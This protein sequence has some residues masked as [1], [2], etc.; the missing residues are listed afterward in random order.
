MRAIVCSQ[1]GSPQDLRL[2]ELPDPVPGPG[3]VLVSVAAVGLGFVD[4]LHVAGRY[5]LKWPLPFTPGSEL[6]G[7][8]AGIGSDMRGLSIGQRV[9]GFCERG[10]LA[11]QVVLAASVCIAVP[12]RLD[13]V[14]AASFPTSYATALFGLRECG[15]LQANETV[16]VLGAAGGVSMAAIDVAKAMGA[17]VIAAA[18]SQAKR[19]L[20]LARG[21]DEAI[22]YTQADWRNDLKQRD[23][24]ARGV[25]LVFDPVGGSYSEAAFRS[26]APG[27]RHLVVGFAAGD[28]PRLPLNLPL[29]KRASLVGV[30]W[31]GAMRSD[32]AAAKPVFDTLFEWI[33]E[34]RISPRAG[35]VYR[36][37]QA[38]DALSAMLGRQAQGKVVIAIR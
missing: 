20:A 29:L 27:G 5:Q 26:L 25:D 10:A 6:S 33:G 23:G 30:D 31:G 32:P 7:I 4:A 18:S 14:Q 2:V 38:G 12:D 19:A 3:Q 21:A 16:L 22:D 9:L 1:Y 13:D 35:Q 28:I 8:V 36:F 17:R 37:E 15:R 11:E 24:L 34:G